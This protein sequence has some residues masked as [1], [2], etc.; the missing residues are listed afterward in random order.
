MERKCLKNPSTWKTHTNSLCVVSEKRNRLN[1]T[2]PDAEKIS[3]YTYCSSLG[4][5]TQLLSAA[6]NRKCRNLTK[7]AKNTSKNE[8]HTPT[9]PFPFFCSPNTSSTFPLKPTQ[10]PLS[11]AAAAQ[12][13]GCARAALP[14]LPWAVP[15]GREVSPRAREGHST[16]WGWTEQD[17]SCS[18]HTES[19]RCFLTVQ[20]IPVF[21]GKGFRLPR[22]SCCLSLTQGLREKEKQLGTPGAAKDRG[23]APPCGTRTPAGHGKGLKFDFSLK[24]SFQLI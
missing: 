24:A 12:P 18:G 22:C 1:K 10:L 16:L 6:T 9:H 20:Q 13:R 4:M 2:C 15:K 14:S 11:V 21:T 8:E 23:A 7:I 19:A 5:E 3:I 17:R